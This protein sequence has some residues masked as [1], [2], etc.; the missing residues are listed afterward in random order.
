MS[1]FIIKYWVQTIFAGVL[2][3]LSVGYKRLVGRFAKEVA[4]QKS[5]KTG[6]QA[7]LRDRIIQSYNHHMTFGYCA[8]HDRDN[9]ANMYDQY[10][11]LGA[12]GVV[13]C[14]Y[15]ELMTLPV[16][17]KNATPKEVE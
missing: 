8:I 12:N 16:R 6:V 7:I 4:D 5:I 15:E 14:L 9:I 2:T 1:E 10:H 3:L 17:A 13:D 11:S